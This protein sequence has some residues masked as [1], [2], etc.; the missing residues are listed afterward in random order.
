M[1]RVSND[2]FD[3]AVET[4]LASVPDEF[5]P[6]LENVIIEVQ[7]APDAAFQAENEVPDDV[8]GFYVGSPLSERGDDLPTM[9][10]RI[11]IFRRN[12]CDMCASR[13]ELIDEIRI[14]VLHEIGHHFG[15]NED[16]LDELGFA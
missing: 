7:D 1:I 16:R 5:R 3:R 12:L 2:E 11:L 9:P 14:T 15:L 8:L 10:D 13:R 4:A 6:H